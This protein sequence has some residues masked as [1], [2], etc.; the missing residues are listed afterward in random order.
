M[1]VD[2]GLDGAVVIIDY[3]TGLILSF[4]KF[5]V[6]DKIVKNTRKPPKNSKNPP[7]AT[8]VERFYDHR[9]FSH[10]LA[11]APGHDVVAYVEK[12]HS[13]RGEGSSSAFKFGTGYGMILGAL[14]AFNIEVFD[15]HPLSW[16]PRMWE[17]IPLKLR[18]NLTSK[19]KSKYAFES[20]RD[21]HGLCFDKPGEGV[22]DAYLIA[23]FGRQRLINE[24]D[25]RRP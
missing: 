18:D 15:A 17:P 13:M 7:K 10:S 16:T 8:R 3:M 21:Q 14:S 6:L 25:L 22:M 2:P 20:M 19:Q 12:V 1:G 5:P 9:A 4:R 24:I 11:V 23:E